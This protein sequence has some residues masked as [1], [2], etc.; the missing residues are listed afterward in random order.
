M[1]SEVC[2]SCTQRKGISPDKLEGE[3]QEILLEAGDLQVSSSKADP[4]SGNQKS[5]ED[6]EIEKLK[7]E[8]RKTELVL[9][10]NRQNLNQSGLLCASGKRPCQ[11]EATRPRGI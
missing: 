7:G 4:G 2:I 3:A 11:S 8:K 10:G 6:F 5:V 9:S 1:L